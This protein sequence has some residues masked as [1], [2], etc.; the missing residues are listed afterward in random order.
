[1]YGAKNAGVVLTERT[2]SQ[3]TFTVNNQPITYQILNTLNF[4]SDRKRMSVIALAPSGDIVLFCKG[5]D[6][7]MLPRLHALPEEIDDTKQ[8]LFVCIYF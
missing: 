1:M 3:V 5:A 2:F 7:V 8:G 6:N 4:T